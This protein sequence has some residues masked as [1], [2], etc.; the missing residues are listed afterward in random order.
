MT[1]DSRRATPSARSAGTDDPFADVERRRLGARRLRSTSG[2]TPPASTS[3]VA[4]ARQRDDG[5]VALPD[6]EDDD[7][8]RQA[9]ARHGVARREARAGEQQRRATT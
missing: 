4:A 8:Q 5:R 7:P 1:S 9:C 6:V 3:I 2:A